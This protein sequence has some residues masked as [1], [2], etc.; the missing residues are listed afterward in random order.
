MKA[1][2]TAL[3]LPALA[4][5]NPH[6]GTIPIDEAYI[7]VC[8]NANEVYFIRPTGVLQSMQGMGGLPNCFSA[9]D[10]NGVLRLLC[11]TKKSPDTCEVAEPGPTV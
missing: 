8:K 6:E 4:H 9:V 5:A 3:L 7:L 11:R 2:L 1:L 10:T